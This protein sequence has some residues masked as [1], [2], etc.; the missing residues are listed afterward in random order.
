M[1]N[2]LSKFFL[3]PRVYPWGAP[4]LFMKKKDGLMRM[5]LDYEL[6]NK[7]SIRNKYSITCNDDLFDQLQGLFVL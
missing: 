4:L 5:C 3:R 7:V 1:L 6:L 2:S